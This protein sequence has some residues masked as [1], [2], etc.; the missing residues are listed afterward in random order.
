MI[1]CFSGT[2]NS[3][4][5]ADYL[6]HAL[7]DEIVRFAPGQMLNPKRINMRV[8]DGRVVWVF[9]VHAWGVP[10]A[11]AR[12][13]SNMGLIS[14]SE[15]KHYM[16]ATCGDDVGLADKQWRSIITGRG[17]VARSAFSVQMPNN[18]VFMPGFD[19]DP[20]DLAAQ[21]LEAMPAR[22]AGVADAIENDDDLVDVVRGSYP[23]FKTRVL[24]PLFRKFCSSTKPFHATDACKGC[25]KCVRNCSVVTIRMVDGKPQWGKECNMCSRCY[26]CCPHRAIAYG[27]ATKGKGQYLCPGYPIKD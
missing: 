12:I 6:H 4:R 8:T 3:R 14:D 17:W 2:G 7:G 18:Y 27:N 9:P 25:G 16:V 10:A 21:K 13:I 20:E 24:N 5:V 15:V 26:H 22:M 23:W 1:A 11:A 19:V